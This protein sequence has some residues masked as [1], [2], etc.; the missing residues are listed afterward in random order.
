[1]KAKLIFKWF[2]FWVGFYWD[3]KN[4]Y[5]YFFPIP[6]FGVVFKFIKTENTSIEKFPN[7]YIIKKTTSCWCG[8]EN[9]DEIPTYIVYHEDFQI[10]SYKTW[11]EASDAI[12]QSI[13]FHKKH[14]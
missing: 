9:K 5:L 11:N 8:E 10:G 2:D 13:R 12:F 7:G 6:M 4:N 14:I 1:M 3:K